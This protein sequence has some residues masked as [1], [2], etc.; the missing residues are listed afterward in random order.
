MN[1][2]LAIIS[3]GVGAAIASGI[4]GIALYKIKR[5]DEKSDQ[6]DDIRAALRYIMLYVIRNQ[7]ID[8]IREGSVSWE[9]RKMLHKWHD[10]YHN[11]LGG[12]GDATLLMD[13]VNDLPLKTE[14]KI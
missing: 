2:V 7:A 13:Q 1:I 10:L 6:K 9:D 5:A 14:A 8:F 4:M 3:G 11:K 12:N